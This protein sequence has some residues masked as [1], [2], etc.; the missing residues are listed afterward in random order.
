M[1]LLTPDWSKTLRAKVGLPAFAASLDALDARV[2]GYHDFLPSVP[3]QQA[4][5]YH[6]FFC[7]DHAVQLQFASQSPQRHTC[8]VDGAE[9]QGEPFDS[10]WL[11]FVNDMLSDAALKLSFRSH[12]EAGPGETGRERH[13]K[14]SFS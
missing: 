10:A 12:L 6:D 1:T 4:G 7:P 13:L 14:C 5:Y 8:P 9:F 2:D 11:W 3:E